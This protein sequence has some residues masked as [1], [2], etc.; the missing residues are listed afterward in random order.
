MDPRKKK[1]HYDFKQ[2]FGID[3]TSLNG[4]AVMVDGDNTGESATGWFADI[5]F[6]EE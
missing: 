2:Y 1:Y 4:Y 6:S 3:V 5:A